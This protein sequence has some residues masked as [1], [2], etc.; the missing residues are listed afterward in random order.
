MEKVQAN[1][2]EE[3]NQTQRHFME[4]TLRKQGLI[5][6]YKARDEEWAWVKETKQQPGRAFPSGNYRALKAWGRVPVLR[7][8]RSTFH[9]CTVDPA[10][11]LFSGK[12]AEIPPWALA[13]ASALL[14]TTVQG[15]K[16]SFTTATRP[17]KGATSTAEL[18]PSCRF[19]VDA[20]AHSPV[21]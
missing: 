3:N 15:A 20:M 5:Y 10:I 16:G 6:A 11:A 18:P 4:E 7:T 13:K 17:Q 2:P 1:I 19:P 14:R 9:F 21:L 8:L 12:D